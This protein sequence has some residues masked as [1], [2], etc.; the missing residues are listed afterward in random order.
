MLERL[1]ARLLVGRVWEEQ[2]GDGPLAE[3]RDVEAWRIAIGMRL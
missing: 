3:R 2:F 1:K